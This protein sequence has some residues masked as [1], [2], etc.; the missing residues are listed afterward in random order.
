MKKTVVTF[1][2]NILM[3][4]KIFKNFTLSLLILTF[5][6]YFPL[7]VS[8]FFHDKLLGA[9]SLVS[10]FSTIPGTGRV[11]G[12]I[13][14]RVPVFDQATEDIKKK[15][16]GTTISIPGLGSTSLPIPGAS[17]SL[18]SIFYNIAK[19]TLKKITNDIVA[20]IR[21]GGR[22]GEPLFI[23]NWEDFLKGVANE[24]SGIFIEEFELT[25]ICR[26]FKPRI[27]LLLGIGRGSPYW[28]RA[29]CTIEDVTRNVEDFYR[30]FK[31]GGWERWFQIT[32]VPQNNF[33]GSYYLTLEEKLIREA[34][35]LEAKQ[36]EAI[37][38]GGFLG[39]EI[40]VNQGPGG[41]LKWEITSPGTLIQDQLEEVFGSD[42]RQLELADE[43]DEVVSAAFQ[44][45]F[46]GLRGRS[47]RG[48]LKSQIPAEDPVTQFNNQN[49]Q[50]DV[51]TL[52]RQVSDNLAFNAKITLASRTVYLKNDSIL[53]INNS[54]IPALEN[55][56]SCILSNSA[57]SASDF[58]FCSN[59]GELCAFTGNKEV[60]FGTATNF[61]SVTGFTN[62]A[63][64]TVNVFGG[65]DPA[66][67]AVKSCSISNPSRLTIATQNI[68]QL[69]KDITNMNIVITELQN[70]AAQLAA[71][72]TIEAINAMIP[73]L[74][75]A[76]DIV[77]SLE[78]SAFAENQQIDV[79]RAAL[80]Q[81]LMACEGSSQ[82]LSP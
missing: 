73:D 24:A 50:N 43:I 45:L 6:F 68:E 9:A 15:E 46:N 41:C 75:A 19:M 61:I 29:S 54:L 26:P 82:G 48:I 62:G 63:L 16:V 7:S 79:E 31:R 69:R 30:D 3:K 55:L 21:T 17:G 32:L 12:A 36:S 10:G 44:A 57:S 38:G 74:K 70:A 81:E 37:A 66:P 1:L 65:T 72:S 51:P 64:C 18:D 49:T 8:A 76:A 56:Q 53:K 35:A 58:T 14:A 20:W 28:E 59:E 25:E 34:A 67:G 47:S 33:Y 80:D 71:A 27:R 2:S 78:S 40:C 52:R 23:R 77:D 5:L 13:G 42:I 60:R 39:T 4:F 11:G 22:N